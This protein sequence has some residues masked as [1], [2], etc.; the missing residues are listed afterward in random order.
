MAPVCIASC[1]ISI[2]ST[3][4]FLCY[5]LLSSPATLLTPHR[6]QEKEAAEAEERK[7]RGLAAQ[8]HCDACGNAVMQS[9][10]FHK[11]DFTYCSEDCAN[12]HKRKLAAD[13]AERRFN[14][15]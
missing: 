4:E 6:L 5:V 15:V 12:A 1:A 7:A 8:G 10:A 9:K 3:N 13:A 14:G 2:T 11:F